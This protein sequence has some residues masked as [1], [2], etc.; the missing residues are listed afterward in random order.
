V[1]AR[2]CGGRN[3]IKSP[4]VWPE[5][6]AMPLLT[7]LL[8]A[9]PFLSLACSRVANQANP[10]AEIRKPNGTIS[11]DSGP[12]FVKADSVIS[13]TFRVENS[14]SS[15]LNIL[16]ESHSCACTTAELKSRVLKPG[17]T[18]TLTLKARLPG[19]FAEKS[20]TSTLKTDDPSNPL[21][22]FEMVVHTY[23]HTRVTPDRVDFGS[24]SASEDTEE[25]VGR[26]RSPSR[27]AW[28]EV[29]EPPGQ[30]G[31][32]APTKIS[33]PREV[34]VSLGSDP[35]VT[36]LRDGVTRSRYELTIT[37][38]PEHKGP[39][40]FSAPV[41]ISFSDG[42]TAELH[43]TWLKELAVKCTPERLHFGMVDPYKGS[44]PTIAV[45]AFSTK[46]KPFRVLE[47]QSDR[48]VTCQ[49]PVSLQ[50]AV[51]TP[52]STTHR[53]LLSLSKLEP[54]QEGK[55]LTGTVRLVT[56]AEG[57]AQIDIPWSVFIRGNSGRIG[58]G[59]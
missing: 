12:V 59:L 23:S 19:G 17:E 48:L 56:D 34:D 31:S 7:A 10:Q 43:V 36:S 58:T 27:S 52:S 1:K 13:H 3:P 29:Y 30:S 37:P 21:R 2:S 49:E 15:V 18:T 53:I 35:I 9:A 8:L 33:T 20:V 42:G 14:S 38:K 47:V 26:V 45:V 25:A 11:F 50:H 5:L 22:R 6:S 4:E 24:F 39:G 57:C 54:G 40:R 41:Q 46:K 28:L 16:D 32:P 44:A 55:A 51:P